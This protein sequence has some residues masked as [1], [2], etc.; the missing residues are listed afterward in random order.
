VVSRAGALTVSE[1]AAAGI[2]A[3]L[4]P[5]PHAVDDH[6]TRNAAFL[7]ESGAA[8]I[9][10]ESKLDAASLSADLRR[11]LSDRAGLLEMAVAA[12]GVSVTDSAE[13]VYQACSEWVKPDESS[14]AMRARGGQLQP[15]RRMRKVHLV[16]IGG[17]GMCGIAEVLANQGFE[18]SGSDLQ[19]SRA[20]RHL[21]GLGVQV[22]YGHDGSLVSDVGQNSCR[23]KS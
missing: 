13:Q 16:G 6:Q 22:S 12:R 2:G 4:V 20:T 11:L 7:V 15:M 18:V 17:S 21:A 23:P 14:E 9:I 10:P 3:I 5:Y 8:E 1:L 19:E